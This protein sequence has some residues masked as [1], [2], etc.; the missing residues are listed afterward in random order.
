LVVVDVS[1]IF[2]GEAGVLT[3]GVAFK[4]NAVKA[5][6]LDVSLSQSSLIAL[7]AD[8]LTFVV[9]QPIHFKHPVERL[10]S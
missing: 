3:A 7:W 1:R 10:M 2:A 6:A 4:T 8:K 5:I 9:L